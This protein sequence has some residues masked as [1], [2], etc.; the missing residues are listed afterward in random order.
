MPVSMINFRERRLSE[1]IELEKRTGN[2]S[3]CEL[4][5]LNL[6]RRV[7]AFPTKL[8]GVPDAFSK[9]PKRELFN[10]YLKSSV[11]AFVAVFIL[12]AIDKFW[13]TEQ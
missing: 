6:K 1:E 10:E 11:G 4:A 5:Y 12:S 8:Y 3:L 2:E 9:K 13:L 7:L